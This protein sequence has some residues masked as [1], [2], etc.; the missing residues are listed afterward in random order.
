MSFFEYFSE[1]A[2]TVRCV[3]ADL[4][5][6]PEVMGRCRTS[7]IFRILSSDRGIGALRVTQ[8]DCKEQKNQCVTSDSYCSKHGFFPEI[9]G[10][11]FSISQ[12]LGSPLKCIGFHLRPESMQRDGLGAF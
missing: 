9:V 10:N 11:V 12:I 6:R 3:S 5:D 1:R 7:R 4:V 8:N 2:D